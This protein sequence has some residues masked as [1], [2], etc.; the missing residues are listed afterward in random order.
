MLFQKLKESGQRPVFMLRHIV[1]RLSYFAHAADNLQRDIKSPIAVAQQKQ[2]IKLGLPANSTTNVLPT[3]ESSAAASQARAAE[4]KS[5][6]APLSLQNGLRANDDGNTP[7][8]GT[9]FPELPSPGLR[10]GETS[11]SARMAG[12]G[13]E[14]DGLPKH[15]YAISIYP[16]VPS[17]CGGEDC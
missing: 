1:S 10:E 8:G 5:H 2:A 6:Q 16:C 7:N 9:S 15:T 11:M 4:G 14:K 17:L 3:I 12:L 13:P